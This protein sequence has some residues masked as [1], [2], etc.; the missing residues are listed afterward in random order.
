M[1]A[2]VDQP[3]IGLRCSKFIIIIFDSGITKQSDEPLFKQKDSI[4]MI[5]I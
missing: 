3:D 1:I 4:I 5:I 2:Y